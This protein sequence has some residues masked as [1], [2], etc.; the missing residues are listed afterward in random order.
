VNS[1]VDEYVELCERLAAIELLDHQRAEWILYKKLDCLWYAEMSDEERA[2]A[3]DRL[4]SRAR[5]WH[6]ARRAED[7]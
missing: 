7:Q 6:D 2:E 1:L 4:V 3:A 5:A